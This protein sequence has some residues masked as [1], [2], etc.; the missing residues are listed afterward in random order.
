MVRILPSFLPAASVTPLCPALF[1]T[2]RFLM[3]KS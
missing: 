2:R 3:R 1:D